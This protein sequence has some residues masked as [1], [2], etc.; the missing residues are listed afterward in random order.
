MHC[1]F[2]CSPSPRA[3]VLTHQTLTL[4]R[5]HKCQHAVPVRDA[6][7]VP[8]EIGVRE[9]VGHTL[10]GHTVPYPDQA[11]LEQGVAGLRG[12][13]VDV[14]AVRIDARKLVLAWFV[15][16]WPAYPSVALG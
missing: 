13:A 1:Q 7:G 3:V 8:E 9:I 15:V 6:A 4:N 12:V 10:D 14:E 11:A 5:A 16:R 2:R